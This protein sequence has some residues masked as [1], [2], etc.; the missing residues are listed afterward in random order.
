MILRIWEKS[1]SSLGNLTGMGGT[2]MGPV[3]STVN[4]LVVTS[5]TMHFVACVMTEE[6]D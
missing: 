4:S 5:L 3:S 6:T 1:M 2:V